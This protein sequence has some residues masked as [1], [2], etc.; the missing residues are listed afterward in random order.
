MVPV[1]IENQAMKSVCEDWLGLTK[2]PPRHMPVAASRAHRIKFLFPLAGEQASLTGYPAVAVRQRGEQV[3]C[4][5]RILA[6]E[7]VTRSVI[8][9]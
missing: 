4:Q 8:G 1:D 5:R 6:K 2:C 3:D 7:G 9:Q